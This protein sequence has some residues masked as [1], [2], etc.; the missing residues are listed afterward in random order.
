MMLVKTGI[1]GLDK[2]LNG[3]FIRGSTIIIMGP[4]GTLK[5]F[6]CQQFIYQGLKSREPC[7]YISTVQELVDVESQLKL[8][9]GWSLKPYIEEGLLRFVDLYA[10]WAAELPD[11]AT[12]LDIKY[13]FKTIC[14]AEEGLSEGRELLHNLSPL[15]NF[16]EDSHP[17][18]R[19]IYALKA[20]VKK[21]DMTMLLVLDE[22]AQEKHIEENIKS[23]SD[24]VLTTDVQAKTGRIKITKAPTKHDLEWH[25]V[26]LTE[27]GVEV[28]VVL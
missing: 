11:I 2:L 20:K 12:S 4:V 27:K 6:I 1:A 13:V 28:E 8:N 9:F 22:G 10:F 23:L 18:L 16:V 26:Y 17:V 24:Y 19:M 5:S 3:G 7:I 15:F 14:E 21:N 25:R